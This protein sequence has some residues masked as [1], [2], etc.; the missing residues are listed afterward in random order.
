[1]SKRSI[2]AYKDILPQLSDMEQKI[3]KCLYTGDYTAENISFYTGINLITVR[4]R[5]SEMFD[6]GV[7][8]QKDSGEYYILHADDME[9]VKQQR[10]EAKY[11]KWKKLGEKH[12]WHFRYDCIDKHGE[13]SPEDY[14]PKK[15]DPEDDAFAF[16]KQQTLN[17]IS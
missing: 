15:I 6:E 1:M 14:K 17:F 12:G 3:Y 2:E 7:I 4:A 5:V 11:L 9:D 13:P 8:A 10:L 16:T